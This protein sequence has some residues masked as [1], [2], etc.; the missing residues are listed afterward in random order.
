M[1][2]RG[3]VALMTAHHGRPD[4]GSRGGDGPLRG[5][6]QVPGGEGVFGIA[7]GE[8]RHQPR[9][10]SGTPPRQPGEKGK[11]AGTTGIGRDSSLIWGELPPGAYSSDA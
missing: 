11:T 6:R 5:R 9:G 7:G 8:A 4:G 3:F 1:P 10:E 2:L